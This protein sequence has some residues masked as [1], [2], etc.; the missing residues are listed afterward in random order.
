MASAYQPQIA[1][2]GVS[3]ALPTA[4][5]D[6]F[7]A[8]VGD[9]VAGVGIDI[10]RRAVRE[11]SIEADRQRDI[12]AS[13][14][15]AALATMRGELDVADNE[16]RTTARAGA[17]GHAETMGRMFDER[18]TALLDS[19]SDPIVRERF[20]P[21][22]AAA[23]AGFVTSADAFERAQTVKATVDNVA[24]AGNAFANRAARAETPQ[25]LQEEIDGFVASIDTL[26]LDER[27]RTE[28]IRD[29]SR[30]ALVGWVGN[31]PPE[32]VAPLLDSGTFDSQLTPEQQDSLRR[33]AGIEIRRREMEAEA[34]ERAAA[35]SAKEEIDQLQR[36]A[37]DGLPIDPARLATA[38]ANAARYGFT[39]DAYDMGKLA[40]KDA[41]N[42]EFRTATPLQIEQ[43]LRTVNGQIAQAGERAEPAWIIARDHLQTMLTA[44]TAQVDNDP[45]AFGASLGIQFAPV[46]LSNPGSVSQRVAAVR[47]TATATGRPP[48]YLSPQEVTQIRAD[49][50]TPTGRRG[51]L[52]A[53]QAF[54]AVDPQA[55]R[56]V[57]EQLAPDDELFIHA[58]GLPG[59][60]G[61]QV[62]EGRSLIG[63]SYTA[64]RALDASIMGAMGSAL[65]LMP[66]AS[67]NNV[68]AAARSLYAYHSSRDNV[69][70]TAEAQVDAGRIRRM[71]HLA[72]GATT[73]ADGQRQGGLGEWRGAAVMLNPRLTQAEFESRLTGLGTTGLFTRDGTAISGQVL[74]QSYV[75]VM[76]PD[77]RYRFR[78]SRGGYAVLRNRRVGAIDLASI[79]R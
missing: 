41:L 43:R 42:Q 45:Q 65:A 53:A 59:Q 12:E 52:A 60:V 34:Q 16:A 46:D 44:R 66:P 38:R 40:V 71:I 35:A 67:R 78:D 58:A 75:P 47:A 50:D 28:L 79:G 24:V 13:R 19:I 76:Q 23:R 69:A 21:Q 31:R 25:A 4:S 72:T 1:P 3:G 17:P 64:P 55:T 62:L 48:V 10:G 36:E 68:I 54:M 61:G 30:Q 18:A 32:Q 56:R 77:G 11:V 5:P 74:R 63:N 26:S 6:A 2:Q 51:A 49:M 27:T 20:A 8:G 73:R 7:G 39:G 9:A 15:M 14:A 57:A 33:G 29:Y 22:I 37:A 70:D